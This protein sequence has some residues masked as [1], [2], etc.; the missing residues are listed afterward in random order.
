MLLAI[1]LSN[2]G[3]MEDVLVSCPP[4]LLDVNA[5]KDHLGNSLLMMAVQHGDTKMARILMSKKNINVN[6]QNIDGNTALHLA[7]FK[8]QLNCIDI[9][10]EHKID[11][12]LPN[13]QGKTAWEMV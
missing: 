13:N 4:N 6:L 8:Q 1:S 10:M 7:I 5:I 3:L 9:L 12:R 2:H 11:E